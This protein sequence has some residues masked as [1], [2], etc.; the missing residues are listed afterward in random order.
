MDY[1][2]G[3]F[4]GEIGAPPLLIAKHMDEVKAGRPALYEKLV[5]SLPPPR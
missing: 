5:K 3:L 2:Y 1:L 4:Q